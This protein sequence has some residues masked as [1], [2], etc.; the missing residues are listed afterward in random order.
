MTV[1]P[2]GSL[3]GRAHFRSRTK[4]PASTA[5]GI[6]SLTYKI[7]LS[8]DPPRTNRPMMVMMVPGGGDR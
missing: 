5:A 2:P 7:G 8:Q 6:L 3:T 1:D 4:K